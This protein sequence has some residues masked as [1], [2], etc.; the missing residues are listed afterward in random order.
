MN[1]IALTGRLGKDE[2]ENMLEVKITVGLI[3]SAGS[4]EQSAKA[5]TKLNV[6]L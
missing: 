2:E 6:L 1:I 3:R 5:L 4:A